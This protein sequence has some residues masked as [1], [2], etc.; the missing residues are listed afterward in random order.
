M[1]TVVDLYNYKKKS[2][3]DNGTGVNR[4]N[5][6][7]GALQFENEILNALIGFHSFTGNDY[8]L[9]FFRKDK[10]AC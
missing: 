3:L 8:M 6:W 5:I 7:L 9:S 1:L 4:N 10:Q 2:Y